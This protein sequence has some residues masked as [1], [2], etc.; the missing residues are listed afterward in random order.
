V[1]DAMT[2]HPAACPAIPDAHDLGVPERPGVD[3]LEQLREAQRALLGRPRMSIRLRLVASLALC[4]LLCCAFSFGSHDL[5]ASLRTKLLVLQAVERLEGHVA[6]ARAQGV[7]VVPADDLQELGAG[8]GELE[9]L[10]GAGAVAVSVAEREA[11]GTLRR[12]ADDSLRP[13]ASP[14][15]RDTPRPR[16]AALPGAMSDTAGV[17][18]AI[19]QRERASINRLLRTAEM[20]PFVLLGFLLLLFGVITFAFARA[21][22]TPIRRLERYTAQVA[23]GDLSLLRPWRKYRDEFS[24]LAVAV[25]KMLAELQAK[26][27]RL[28]KGARLAAVGTLTSGVAHELNNPLNNISITTEALMERLT[29]MGPEETWRHLQDIYFETERASEIVK[30]LLDFTRTETPALVSLDL[31]EVLKST[32]RLAQNEMTINNVR[33]TFEL[34]EGLPRVQGTANQLRQV[35]LNLLLNAIHAMPGGGTLLVEANA[36][37]SGKVCVNISDTG[38]GIA[39][40][41]LP[42]IFDPFFTTKEP[43]KGAGLGLSVS[44]GI[45]RQFGGDIL[46]ASEAGKGTT[47]HVCL[48]AA[49]PAPAALEERE[50]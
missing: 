46:V 42:R 48:L 15:G 30:S 23:A 50:R 38:M 44:L 28:V 20:G 11:L 43:G 29:S 47:L 6:R 4:F 1:E 18:E 10:L 34:P 35:F 45:I 22:V 3:N 16:A 13:S 36:H 26:Q 24:D 2:I 12:H 5:L 8:A 37:S 27:D 41:V 40:D 17:L 9:A 32:F 49:E 39:T 21:L 25:N 14:P 31:G 33:L 19:I 7:E